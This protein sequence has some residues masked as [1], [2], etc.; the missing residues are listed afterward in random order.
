[1]SRSFWLGHQI[2]NAYEESSRR[3]ETRVRFVRVTPDP[4]INTYMVG[5]SVLDVRTRMESAALRVTFPVGQSG[6]G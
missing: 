1:V 6:A 4:V 5:Y 2:L 3:G